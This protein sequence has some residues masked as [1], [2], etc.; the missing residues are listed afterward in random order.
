MAPGRNKGFAE[1]QKALRLQKRKLKEEAAASGVTADLP[2]A[3]RIKMNEP[4]RKK[5]K[6]TEGK[7]NTNVGIFDE[8]VGCAVLLDISELLA[9]RHSV[10][11]SAGGRE[12]GIHP[13]LE[14]S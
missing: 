6:N 4:A 14:V 7:A 5:H 2:G 1:E 12:G 13:P 9:V 10:V 3:A 8:A 11:L